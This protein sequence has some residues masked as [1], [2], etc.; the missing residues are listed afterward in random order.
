LF[1]FSVVDLPLDISQFVR[2]AFDVLS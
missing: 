1:A 2:E